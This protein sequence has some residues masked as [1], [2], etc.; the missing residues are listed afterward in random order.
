VRLRP[1][2]PY[3]GFASLITVAVILRVLSPRFSPVER[4]LDDPSIRSAGLISD[5]QG[6]LGFL[7]SASTEKIDWKINQNPQPGVHTLILFSGDKAKTNPAYADY[8]QTIAWVAEY[9]T[10]VVD[11]DYVQVLAE[12]LTSFGP[13]QIENPYERRFREDATVKEFLLW[14]LGHESG[15]AH[16]HDS[17]RHFWLKSFE[18]PEPADAA[19]QAIEKRADGYVAVLVSSSPS[20]AVDLSEMLFGILNVNLEA[21]MPESNLQGPA[22]QIFSTDGIDVL[23]SGT[24]PDFI[25][26]AATILSD[27]H[28]PAGTEERYG[29]WAGKLLERI[30][31][32]KSVECSVMTRT[33]PVSGDLAVQHNGEKPVVYRTPAS[34]LL[35]PGTYQLEVSAKG[36]KTTKEQITVRDCKHVSDVN[37]Q[38]EKIPDSPRPPMTPLEQFVNRREQTIRRIAHAQNLQQQGQWEAA[39]WELERAVEIDPAWSETLFLQAFVKEH[40]NKLTEAKTLHDRATLL[41]KAEIAGY[42]LGI[43]RLDHIQTEMADET[44]TLLKHPGDEEARRSTAGLWLELGRFDLARPLVQQLQERPGSC[45]DD[46]NLARYLLASSKIQNAV[47]LLQ[48]TAACTGPESVD[49]MI[50]LATQLESLK[51]DT[52]AEHWFVLAY[53]GDPE[54]AWV[55]L[56]D[57]LR[58]HNRAKEALSYALAAAKGTSDDT[59]TLNE[60]A[61]IELQ[62][63][64]T[65]TAELWFK[66]ALATYTDN[67]D[68]LVGLARIAGKRGQW[69][70]ARKFCGDAVKGNSWDDF[71][72]WVCV[73]DAEQ[74][75]GHAQEALTAYQKAIWLRPSDMSLSSSIAHLYT[76]A[77]DAGR[78]SLYTSFATPKQPFTE[79]F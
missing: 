28:Y 32:S 40:D 13:P 61:K 58:R 27:I 24:H 50:A 18:A 63:G 42:E 7:N 29:L 8:V 6:V 25:V 65:D 3:L 38:M 62:L 55:D 67:S 5:V 64:R 72:G 71:D 36:F 17:T 11:V 57:F 22:I 66:R 34:L 4:F 20:Q 47:T 19:N 23:A 16:Y 51:Q 68:A 74:T 75:L 52:E 76:L 2:L 73:G 78:A 41:K 14:V 21:R 31:S 33:I 10:I 37:L 53:K 77:S 1:L 60:I 49:A 56:A 43:Y 39:E 45:E 70:Q 54:N 26:R 46:V 12:Q 79:V 30:K 44:R 59:D 15:H 35:A 69:E 9:D 48:Q